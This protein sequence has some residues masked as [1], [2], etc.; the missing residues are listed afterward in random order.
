MQA[1]QGSTVVEDIL[2]F[3]AAFAAE[4]GI[5]ASQLQNEDVPISNEIAWKWE[6][7]KPLL[8][9]DQIELL[10]T[11]MRKLHKWYMEVTK[12]GRLV[13]PVEVTQEHFIGQDEIQVY[14]E[15]LF[16]LYKLYALDLSIVSIY[17]L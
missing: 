12:T 1:D 4:A 7:R 10:P 8:P 16:Q 9:P 17:C 14:L 6:D 11:Q 5:T 3:E 13:I 15:E 2:S